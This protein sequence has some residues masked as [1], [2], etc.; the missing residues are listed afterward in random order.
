MPFIASRTS[1]TFKKYI[2]NSIA[3]LYT[4]TERLRT[5][6]ICDVTKSRGGSPFSHMLIAARRGNDQRNTLYTSFSLI[7]I[8]IETLAAEG[9]TCMPYQAY[10]FLYILETEVD[11]PLNRNNTLPVLSLFKDYI[12]GCKSNWGFSGSFHCRVYVIC[13]QM[14]KSLYMRNLISPEV[15]KTPLRHFGPL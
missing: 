11:D 12:S 2:M 6:N 4:C 13:L 9:P 8:T 1:G 15:S 5:V 3:F 14:L 7:S 10:E